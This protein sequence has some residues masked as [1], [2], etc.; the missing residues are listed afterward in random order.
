M[1]ALPER[2][3]LPG[4][5]PVGT[6]LG[7]GPGDLGVGLR[8]TSPPEPLSMGCCWGSFADALWGDAA[9]D[10][11][12]PGARGSVPGLV[13][14]GCAHTCEP[15]PVGVRA[16]PLGTSCV[17]LL[18]GGCLGGEAGACRGEEGAC[19]WGCL[20]AGSR[21][22]PSLCCLGTLAR[23]PLAPC[24]LCPPRCSPG[25]PAGWGPQPLCRGVRRPG[26]QLSSQR[27]PGQLPQPRALPCGH[28]PPAPLLPASAPRV[29]PQRPARRGRS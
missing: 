4:Q 5:D 6:P 15:R 12:P 18:L 8:R 17:H 9:G 1:G 23:R 25:L 10:P 28:H 19:V 29:P 7:L 2:R 16:P 14:S 26:M 20:R 27:A 3:L 22:A 13:A 11:C 24:Q 21:S